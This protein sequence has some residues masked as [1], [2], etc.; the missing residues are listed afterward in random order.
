MTA[1]QLQRS[2]WSIRSSLI[3]AFFV[4]P[5]LVFSQDAGK[6]SSG[7]LALC[8]RSLGCQR[9]PRLDELQIA[10]GGASKLLARTSALAEPTVQV[11]VNSAGQDLTV[12]YVSVVSLEC[13][14]G[15]AQAQSSIIDNA[16]IAH[17]CRCHV[18]MQLC[19]VLKLTART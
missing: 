7:P 11:L 12:T 17:T 3:L 13:F 6:A 14:V 9:H 2:R 5:G 18:C 10:T 8:V 4:G 19:M 1:A 16:A 15:T